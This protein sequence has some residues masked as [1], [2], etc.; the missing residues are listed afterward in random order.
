MLRRGNRRASH[1]NRTRGV[2][3]MAVVDGG[4]IPKAA[5]P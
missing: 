2:F 4:G 1:N 3:G 5:R